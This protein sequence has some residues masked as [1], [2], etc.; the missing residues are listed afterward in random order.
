MNW[1]YMYNTLRWSKGFWSQTFWTCFHD[2]ISAKLIIW[3]KNVWFILYNHGVLNHHI[4]L[5]LF[6][7]IAGFKDRKKGNPISHEGDENSFHS[8]DTLFANHTGDGYKMWKNCEE[9]SKSVEVVYHRKNE[10]T[11]GLLNKVYFPYDPNVSNCWIW[12]HLPLMTA[13]NSFNKFYNIHDIETFER[14][15]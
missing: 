13:L 15:W 8:F 12:S 11:C 5:F 2:K 10:N 14:K 4:C 1:W 6:L 7:F 9:W 3:C